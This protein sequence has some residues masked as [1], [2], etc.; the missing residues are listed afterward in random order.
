[1]VQYLEIACSGNQGRSPF[2]ELRLQNRFEDMHMEKHYKAVS[3]GVIVDEILGYER[4]EALPDRWVKGCVQMGYDR[5]LFNGTNFNN[6]KGLLEK[7]E[8]SPEEISMLQQ[9]ANMALMTFQREE[10][11]YREEAAKRLGLRGKLKDVTRRE[12]TRP[13]E[14]L[15]LFL[16][17]E[18]RHIDAA[19][20]IYIASGINPEDPNFPQMATVANYTGEDVKFT[21]A[22]GGTFND[23]LNMARTIVKCMDRIA[24]RFINERRNR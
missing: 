23:Y 2:G 10:L 4:G 14:G 16:G 6:I 7:N 21:D 11:A 24:M 5:G 13:R 18:D 8:L 19:R 1:M 3:S 15:A 12:K 9:P 22:F 20:E 17:Y